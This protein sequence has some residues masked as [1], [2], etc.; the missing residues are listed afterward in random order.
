M[1]LLLV[2]AR[3]V[4][5]GVFAV[6]D[7]AH[8]ARGDYARGPQQHRLRGHA[9]RSGQ[10]RDDRNRGQRKPVLDLT[11]IGVGDTGQLGSLSQ[12]ELR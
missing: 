7:A 5:D 2:K 6:T 8:R 10:G 9:Q 3:I 12:R 1:F 11:E 4:P